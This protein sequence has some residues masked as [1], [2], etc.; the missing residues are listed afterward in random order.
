[1]AVQ[2]QIRRGSALEWTTANPLLAEGELAVELD[3]EKF[4]IGN[5]IL[6]WNELSYASGPI[7]PQ[8]DVGPQGE[9]GPQG[10]QGNQINTL[11]DVPD[12]DTT[13]LVN[14]S[15]LVYE[16]FSSVWKSSLDLPPQNLDGGQF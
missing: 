3:T 9:V 4:K 7:G 13:D 11:T 14:G 8:G 12:V 6:Y 10:L 16:T 5:G 1:M 15:V 2:I